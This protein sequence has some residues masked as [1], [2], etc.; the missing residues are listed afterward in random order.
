MGRQLMGLYT[1]GIARQFGDDKQSQANAQ[2][3]DVR[4][5]QKVNA[6]HR[7]AFAEKY[8]GQVEHCLR[9]IMERLQV[10]LD[11]RGAVDLAKPETW[12]LLPREI[13]DLAD[14]AHKLNQ[15]RQT[16]R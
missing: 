14:A 9:L 15:I 1:E 12:V 10:G 7:E 6:A 2:T 13:N 16:L 3:Q 4:I 8:P 11:K 5:L